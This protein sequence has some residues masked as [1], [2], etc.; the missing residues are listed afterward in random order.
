MNGHLGNP[1]VNGLDVFLAAL[2][3]EAENELVLTAHV[4]EIEFKLKPEDAHVGSLNGQGYFYFFNSLISAHYANPN[5]TFC[6]FYCLIFQ[7]IT[8]GKAGVN[9]L[10]VPLAAQQIQEAEYDLVLIAVVM[11]KEEKLRAEDAHV[12]SPNGQGNILMNCS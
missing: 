6:F 9:G 8:L 2:Q 7:V 4:K 3:E 1:G 5:S 12:G 10:D 11:G